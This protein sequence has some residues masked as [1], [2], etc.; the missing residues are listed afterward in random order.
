MRPSRLGLALVLAAAATLRFWALGHDL[1]QAIPAEEHETVQRAFLMMRDGTLNPGFYDFGQLPIYLQLAVSVVRFLAG[2]TSG[3]WYSLAQATVHPFYLW[4]R[5]SMAAAGTI[6][7]LLVYFSGLRWGARPA[8]LAA[9]LMAVLPLHVDFSHRAVPDALMTMVVALTL[10]LTLRAS[11]KGTLRAFIWAGAVA[12]LAVA[13]RY[14]AVA[15]ILLPLAACVTQPIAARQRATLALAVIAA[16]FGGFLAG[17]PYTVLDF[18]AFLNRF[19]ELAAAARQ[20]PSPD[21]PAALYYL[22]TLTDQFAW[23]GARGPVSVVGGPG[24]LLTLFG[25]GIAIVRVFDR[26]G[27]TRWAIVAFFTLAHFVFIC[28]R[29]GVDPR[30]ILPLLPATVLLTASAVI[31]GVSLLRRLEFPRAVRTTLIALLTLAVIAPA[32]ASAIAYNRALSRTSTTRLAYEWIRQNLPPTAVVVVEDD[33]LMIPRGVVE[34][35]GI[36]ELTLKTCDE[37]TSEGVE[38]LVASST[39]YGKYFLDPRKYRQEY[40]AYARLF[41]EATEVAKFTPT[42]RTPG[43]EL[44]VLKLI[45]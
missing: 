39:A 37:F 42:G 35:R 3:E 32:G 21:T 45:P 13:T 31:I 27:Q 14:H 22:R 30:Y 8:L 19:A 15:A 18:P 5:A 44:R 38:Y 41:S 40:Q 9:G 16:A 10:L 24:L 2:A 1:P 33:A 34:G 23:P 12:G 29:P 36:R 6:T 4:G 11:E 43:P 20:A 17:A 25:F 28:A 26:P 7:V